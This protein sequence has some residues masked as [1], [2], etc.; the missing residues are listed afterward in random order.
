MTT[1]QSRAGLFLVTTGALIL[2][3]TGF[4]WDAITPWAYLNVVGGLTLTAFAWGIGL[5]NW[6][7][8]LAL[9]LWQALEVSLYYPWG[10]PGIPI[11]IFINPMVGI[12]VLATVLGSSRVPSQIRK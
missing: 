2:A 10:E 4:C 8:V 6:W 3:A 7:A 5:R 1:F 9:P 12:A 11:S